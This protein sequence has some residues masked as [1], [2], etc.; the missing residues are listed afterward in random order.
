MKFE[1]ENLTVRISAYHACL[2]RKR[3]GDAPVSRFA[4]QLLEA[5][6][7]EY[8]GTDPA[9]GRKWN[10]GPEHVDRDRLVGMFQN[11]LNEERA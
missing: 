6:A 4:A 3:K 11:R 5:A 8:A 10:D 2:L 1:R 7:E 9:E